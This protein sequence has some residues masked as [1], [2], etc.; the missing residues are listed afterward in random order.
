M[1][2]V[3]FFSSI[4]TALSLAAAGFAQTNS[5]TGSSN[6]AAY[7]ARLTLTPNTPS[8]IALQVLPKSACLLHAEGANDPQHSLKL[9]ADDA[10]L[11]RFHVQAPSAS[12]QVSSFQVDCQA[13]GQSTQFPLQLRPNASPT[14]DMPAPAPDLVQTAPEA[15]LLP[16]LSASDAAQLSRNELRSRGYPPRPDAQQAPDAYAVWL[17]A[18]TKPARIVNPRLVSNP[19]VTHALPQATTASTT[20]SHW[21]GY[22][23]NGPA[24]S[25]DHVIGTWYVP[26]LVLAESGQW[27]YS[28]FWV[29]IDGGSANKSDPGANDLVQ[30]GTE[31]DIIEICPFTCFTFTNYYG[32][33]EILPQQA[34]EQRIPNL[35]VYPGDEMFAEIDMCLVPSSVC[36]DAPDAPY[37]SLWIW[38]LTHPQVVSVYDLNTKGVAGSDAEWI[39]ERPKIGNSL[40]DLSAYTYATMS[41]AYACNEN[42]STLVNCMSYHSPST[43]VT[44]YQ[45]WMYNGSDLLSAVFPVNDSEMEFFWYNWH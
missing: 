4:A 9:F 40:S 15:P 44:S 33:T 14:A 18:V 42:L 8:P 20:N 26:G 38:D 23:L 27:T 12:D 37:A 34:T 30:E 5:V 28:S 13:D 21:S 43:G 10:G 36:F 31:Q 1:Q 24:N 11:V 17:K 25:F 16:A 6:T 32:W 41:G 2:R 29:G 22:Q 39:M 19:G 7:P 45:I 3:H 35:S